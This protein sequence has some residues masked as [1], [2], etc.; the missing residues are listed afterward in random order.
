MFSVTFPWEVSH[1]GSASLD[2][3]FFLVVYS[4]R[5][6][7]ALSAEKSVEEKL[8]QIEKRFHDDQWKA[9]K[10]ERDN[11]ELAVA[12]WDSE[13]EDLHP[14]AHDYDPKDDLGVQS[15]QEALTALTDPDIEDESAPVKP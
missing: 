2:V 3:V 12:F 7:R 9:V 13:S 11:G 6:M 1:A 14:T 15:I 10:F 5:K 4:V 8:A